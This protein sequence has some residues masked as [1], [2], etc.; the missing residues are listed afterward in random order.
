LQTS[1]LRAENGFADISLLYE[2]LPDLN[3]AEIDTTLVFMDKKLQAPLLI[4]AM[5]GGHPELKH[6]NRSLAAV[7]ARTGI[8]MAVGSQT[9]GL[10]DPGV[11]DTYYIARAAN[12]DGLLLANVSALTPPPQVKEAVEMIAADGVQLHLNVAQE[13]AMPEGDRNFRGTLANIK[14]IA[15]I[16][17]VPVIVKE[18]GFG[19]SREAVGKLYEV[20]VRYI[21]IGGK[22]GTDFV[23]IEQMRSGCTCPD[24]C[25]NIGI[26]A[27]N[28]LLEALSLDLPGAVLASGGFRG[29]NDLVCALALGARLVGM[30]SHFLQVLVRGSEKELEEHI[31]MLIENLRQMMLMAG[32]ANLPEL[33]EKPV[34][35]TGKTAEWLIRR[36]IDID[37]Y[38]RRGPR[39]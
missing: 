25:Q 4:N 20:G 23:R 29:G 24:F 17:E 14:K 22:G 15:A 3:L 21:D 26:S 19:L 6:L 34:V 31:R 28:S 16:S 30:A 27:A 12:P 32:A 36:G 13:L 5:T 39:R 37:R 8:A 9:A 18:V 1:A 38:A 35:I 10:E 2:A 33:A 7:A 11:R